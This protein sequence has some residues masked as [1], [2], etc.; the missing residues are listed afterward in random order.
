M[1][2]KDFMFHEGEGAGKQKPPFLC[3]ELF[4]FSEDVWKPFTTCLGF[5]GS[6]I[7]ETV[8]NLIFQRK[9][10]EGL[11][12]NEVKELASA[13]RR[14][15][16]LVEGRLDV[17]TFIRI[18]KEE[19]TNVAYSKFDFK[20]RFDLLSLMNEIVIKDE[21]FDEMFEIE[22][23]GNEYINLRIATLGSHSFWGVSDPV[24]GTE[25]QRIPYYMYLIIKEVTVD[26]KE[27]GK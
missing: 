6:E 11:Q 21:Q 26:S 5:E 18:F 1:I 22:E 23:V 27:K 17:F 13:I 3:N 14:K 15:T 7:L 20:C 16:L 8:I 25:W 24:N 12:L 10:S 2:S 19:V 4:R 9:T